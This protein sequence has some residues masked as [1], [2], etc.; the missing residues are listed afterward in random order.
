MYKFWSIIAILCIVMQS[1]AQS[2]RDYNWLITKD[3]N[4]TTPNAKGTLVEF[5]DDGPTFTY[6]ETP[7]GI[8][9][10]GST[11]SDEEGNLLFYTN[12]C[13]IYNSAYELMEN[14]DD[15]NAVTPL[16]D[17][18]CPG[19]Y[20]GTG[21]IIL[22]DPGYEFGYYVI[23]K[24]LTITDSGLFAFS[25]RYTYIDMQLADGMGAVTSKNGIIYDDE[26]LLKLGYM[27]ACKHANGV[28]WWITQVAEQSNTFYKFL[29]NESGI[30]LVDTQN[31]GPMHSLDDG[32]QSQMVYSRDGSKYVINSVENN[33]LLYNF[34]RE[35]G[36]L[37]YLD[38]L[39]YDVEFDSHI[40]GVCFS[41]NNR[42]L[43][44][45]SQDTLYQVDMEEE[46]Y[47]LEVVGAYDGFVATAAEIP[48][49]WSNMLPG[50]DCKIYLPSAA[51]IRYMH[52]IHDPDQKGAA[53]NFEQHA[54]RFDIPLPS[55]FHF[56][57]PFYRMDEGAPCDPTLVGL[58]DRYKVEEELY[59][60]FPN[61][62]SD[63]LY[64][65]IEP[66][67][68]VERYELFTASGSMIRTSAV[69]ELL[70]DID[71]HHLRSGMYFLRLYDQNGNWK[72]EKVIKQ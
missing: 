11:I 39:E 26:P 44:V 34:N 36:E 31:V 25:M 22:P 28:D 41:P 1:I 20:P 33:V 54:I 60:V 53:C 43:Y 47:H 68:E 15:I 18:Y 16:F 50:P 70:I 59:K 6:A 57:I 37:I 55:F 71:I 45:S 38:Q 3:Y 14:G 64:I 46:E 13:S 69:E 40:R 58:F 21:L 62:V 72:V 52:V 10:Q 4:T 5:R 7:D 51:G 12:G 29:L 23:H 65:D 49:V 30:S 32:G 66:E 19:G 67:A 24:P 42:F 35:F 48:T 63:I 61:P 56:P 9:R 2:K 17:S 27:Q 8:F